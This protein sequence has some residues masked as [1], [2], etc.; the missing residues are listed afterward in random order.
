[1]G[2][3]FQR[4]IGVMQDVLGTYVTTAASNKKN[5]TAVHKTLNDK[6]QITLILTQ[7]SLLILHCKLMH[8]RITSLTN[9]SL[10]DSRI[11]P[12]PHKTADCFLT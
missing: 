2:V 1:M 7:I 6:S 8:K 11:K 4:N 3:R 10:H 5:N 12:Y 9:G